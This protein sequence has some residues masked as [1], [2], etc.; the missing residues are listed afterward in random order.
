MQRK[1]GLVIDYW[2]YSAWRGRNANFT[3]KIGTLSGDRPWLTNCSCL[4]SA[5]L[6]LQSKE[7]VPS[8]K[9]LVWAKIG[10]LFATA[11][12][13][14][15][16][17]GQL[18]LTLTVLVFQL[19]PWMS[20]PPWLV[21]VFHNW[22]SAALPLNHLEGPREASQPAAQMFS[23]C[24]VREPFRITHPS[25]I[26]FSPLPLP[27]TNM[28]FQDNLDLGNTTNHAKSQDHDDDHPLDLTTDEDTLD[29]K[30]DGCSIGS[31]ATTDATSDR[32]ST[33]EEHP[34]FS[35]DDE[36]L[37]GSHPNPG[38]HTGSPQ[39]LVEGDDSSI[40]T[41]DEFA[42]TTVVILG[43]EFLYCRNAERFVSW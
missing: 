6:A 24:M 18:Q 19:F 36:D 29:S 25:G 13:A 28:A 22:I 31:H 38:W 21:E 9:M 32:S 17:S 3:E 1:A 20:N 10:T 39:P 34:P 16:G 8:A 15:S 40:L 26:S 30:N 5:V 42:S 35:T 37:T 11:P 4:D 2:G 43:R 41:S 27:I 23:P 12:G 7:N 14:K 33:S